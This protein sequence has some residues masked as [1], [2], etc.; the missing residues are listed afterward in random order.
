MQPI[1]RSGH[2]LQQPV[3]KCARSGAISDTS[4][5]SCLHE[6]AINRKLGPRSLFAERN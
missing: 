3:E 2:K 6:G 5:S 4:V 1:R